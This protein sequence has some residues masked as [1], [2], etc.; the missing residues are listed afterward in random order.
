MLES[1]ADTIVLVDETDRETGTGEKMAVHRA[2][3][4]H[5]AFSVMI[6]DRSGRLLLQKRFGGK[7]HSGRLWTNSCCG[8]P[9]PGEAVM[10]AAARRLK[11]EMGLTAPL[12]HLGTIRYRADVGP[13]MIEHEL[14]HVFRGIYDGPVNPDPA[15]A[16]EF[17]WVAPA[18]IVRDMAAAPERYSAWFLAYAEAK[19]PIAPPP[20][21]A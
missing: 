6:W 15:E 14:V 18:E 11:E 20:A 2:G 3:A 4:L 1:T 19:W 7:Y 12:E 10:T 8:H 17:A 9:G 16:E 21:R 13:D 5:R